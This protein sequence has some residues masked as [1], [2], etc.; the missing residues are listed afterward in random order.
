MDRIIN[1]M[2]SF[3][4]NVSSP[5]DDGRVHRCMSN[6]KSKKNKDGWY[7]LHRNDGHYFSIFGCWLRGEKR[8]VSTKEI[9]GNYEE[10]KKIWEDLE[11]KQAMEE[12]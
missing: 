8:K 9:E 2:H 12:L 10:S 4:L 5:I 1:E 11:A 6:A 7:I 3:G